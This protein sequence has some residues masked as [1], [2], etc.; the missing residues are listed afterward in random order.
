MSKIKLNLEVDEAVY[1]SLKKQ[2]E[3][4]KQKNPTLP[5]LVNFDDFLN[6]ILTTYA[7]S[8][9]SFSKMPFNIKDLMNLLKIKD[10][11]IFDLFGN[12]N[13]KKETDVEKK[14][15]VDKTKLK[16]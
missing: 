12:S 14:E 7:K 8:I 2:F 16:N 6:N 13:K 1:Q 10:D 3:D 15:E 9:D 4:F 5:G 11:S